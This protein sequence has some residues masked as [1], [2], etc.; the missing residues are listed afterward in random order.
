MDNAFVEEV[1]ASLVREF[2][3]RKVNL[4]RFPPG[5]APVGMMELGRTGRAGGIAGC[6][7]VYPTRNQRGG[8]GGRLWGERLDYISHS[9]LLFP[10]M[11][12][13]PP[14]QGKPILTH[15]RLRAWKL[16]Q[17]TRFQFSFS[18]CL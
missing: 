8:K 3:S 15:T 9:A 5:C 6:W 17:E 1:A 12:L 4:R 2:L 18:C 16:N 10:A 11:E 14:A 7:G 13:L